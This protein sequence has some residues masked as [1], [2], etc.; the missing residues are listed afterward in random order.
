[1]D[2]N[3]LNTIP[4]SLVRYVKGSKTFSHSRMTSA[5]HYFYPSTS[6]DKS[7]TL[8]PQK[9][10]PSHLG[11]ILGFLG[12]LRPHIFS[13]IQASL[14]VLVKSQD[15]QLISNPDDG[16]F[17]ALLATMCSR[18]FLGFYISFKSKTMTVARAYFPNP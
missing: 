14:V 16:K 13:V 6:T 10:R 4:L 2:A 8:P 5:E 15:R 11:T 9:Y 12:M 17:R 7:S 3:P 18:T 1:M